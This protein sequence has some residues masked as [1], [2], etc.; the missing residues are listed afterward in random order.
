M[1]I[2]NKES[3]ITFDSILKGSFRIYQQKEGY[4][5]GTDAILLAA[6]VNPIKGRLIDLGAGVGTLSIIIARKTIKSQLILLKKI[7]IH[8]NFYQKI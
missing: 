5:V 3:N 6:S 2:I 7:L 4:R 1:E 8:L